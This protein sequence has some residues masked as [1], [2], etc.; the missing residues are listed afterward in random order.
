MSSTPRPVVIEM[1]KGEIDASFHHADTD[2]S[3][4]W[5]SNLPKILLLLS[6]NLKIM[7]SKA[8]PFTALLML[9]M[10]R[11]FI[12]SHLTLLQIRSKRNAH[13][14]MLAIVQGHH[15]AA[16]DPQVLTNHTIVEALLHEAIPTEATHVNAHQDEDVTMTMAEIIL[17]GAHH[18]L[19]EE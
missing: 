1:A 4:S 6:K 16:T 10:Q 13:L 15:H 8:L 11:L 2:T 9:V 19:G 14:A 3:G 18:H 12:L 17:G 7:N 5:N